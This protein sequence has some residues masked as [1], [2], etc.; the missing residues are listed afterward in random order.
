[1][2]GKNINLSKP[3]YSHSNTLS[4]VIDWRHGSDLLS[5]TH[6]MKNGFVSGMGIWKNWWK[7]S[8]LFSETYLRKQAWEYIIA[9]ISRLAISTTDKQTPK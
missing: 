7:K 4:K 6:M 1:V 5:L 2:I 8:S 9:N 3:I